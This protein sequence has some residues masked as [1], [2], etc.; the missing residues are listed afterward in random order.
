MSCSGTTGGDDNDDGGGVDD[1]DKVMVGRG[2]SG[3]SKKKH[4]SRFSSA[5]LKAALS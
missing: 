3:L 4:K 1:G 5:A 2:K